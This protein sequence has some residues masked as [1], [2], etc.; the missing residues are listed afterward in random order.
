MTGRI[1]LAEIAEFGGD[2]ADQNLGQSDDNETG[3]RVLL[4]LDL[5]LCRAAQSINVNDGKII[6]RG[7]LTFRES[8]CSSR[9]Q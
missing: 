1:V 2:L 9:L 4:D 6:L 7:G 3:L 5:D 8:L